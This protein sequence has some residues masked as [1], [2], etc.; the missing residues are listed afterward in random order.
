MN[1]KNAFTLIELLIVVAIIG[2]LAAIAVPNFLNAQTR[3]KV[4]RVVSDLKAITQAMEMY[5]ID[6]N[7]YI[8]ESE[9]YISLNGIKTPAPDAGLYFLLTP[10][11]YMTS[12]PTDPFENKYI[13][14]SGTTGVDM[15]E[16]AVAPANPDP[17]KKFYN[18][19]S[20]GPDQ[21]E[22]MG[23]RSDLQFGTTII[24]YLASNGL[25]SNGDIYLFG[26]N[27]GVMKGP[28]NVDGRIY[29]GTMPPN[30]NY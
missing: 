29:N 3:A 12:I 9:S 19:N 13:E 24:T 11:S 1:K 27:P 2:I 10:V 28:I 26:G 7:S 5:Y 8:N 6:H 20:R 16:V 22:D 25:Y 30:P 17:Q 4:A 18:I 23:A 15:Y 14:A 21:D